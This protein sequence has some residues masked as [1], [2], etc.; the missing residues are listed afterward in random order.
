VPGV[1]TP[2]ALAL[3]SSTP[4]EGATGVARTADITLV[5]NNA[6]ALGAENNIALLDSGNEIVAV[7]NSISADRKTVTVNPSATLAAT[8]AHTV[9][10]AVRDLYG[11]TLHATVEY[12]T[13]S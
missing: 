3:S 13:G 9:A 2:S 8:T 6:L 11:Q 7:S 12:T 4:A 1:S 5:F 10:I